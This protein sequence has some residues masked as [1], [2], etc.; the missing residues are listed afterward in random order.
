MQFYTKVPIA[1]SLNPISYESQIVSFGS[2]FS[3]NMGDK[4]Q[5]YQF[6]NLTN[7]FGI[8]FNAV[9]IEKVIKRAILD[10]DFTEEDVFFYDE[11]WH[12]FEVHSKLSHPDK[13]TFLR[14]L[15]EILKTTRDQ[16]AVTSHFIIT[17]GTSWVYKTKNE[18]NIV[19]NCH[20]I[21]QKEFS[22]TLLSAFETLQSLKNSIKL[23]RTIN[24]N[25]HFL[26][27]VSPVRHLKDG[28]FEN[29]V[30]KSNLISA[31]YQLLKSENHQHNLGYFP[32]YEIMMDELRDYRFYNEDLLHPSETAIDYIW[33]RF[34]E[35]N[36]E[37]SSI[38]TMNDIEIIRKGM[39]HRP[40]N[41]DSI[42]HQKFL[43]NLKNQMDIV[44]SKYPF[45]QF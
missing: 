45:M 44:Q 41:P 12:C 27:T 16:I 23:V 8:I 26:C 40:F 28:F 20:K 18:T 37:K 10:E 31:V 24:P 33:S 32:S 1:A 36:I 43:A 17:L 29:Q 14:N 11:K 30:S 22:K 7:P 13:D 9:S 15:N 21:P 3:E 38:S 35:T 34:M 2:C 39:Q 5:Y 4:F 25:C 42:S 19:A 6:R